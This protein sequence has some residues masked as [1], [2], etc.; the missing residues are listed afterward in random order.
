MVKKMKVRYVSLSGRMMHGCNLVPTLKVKQHLI[1]GSRVSISED[2]LTIAVAAWG[3]DGG[4]TDAGHVRIYSL[5]GGQWIQLGDID[6]EDVGTG[7]NELST[8]HSV[9]ISGDGSTIAFGNGRNDA[10]G[11]DAGR[12]RVYEMIGDSWSQRGAAIDGQS[13]DD[14]SGSSISLSRDGT[15]LAVGA[16]K[17]NGESGPDS[18]GVRVFEWTAANVWDLVGEFDGRPHLT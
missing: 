14:F 18:G 6:G 13:S 4:G 11:V 1:P 15:V 9:S 8:S 7:T 16:L 17:K 5:F 12:V 3:N 10:A 2:G